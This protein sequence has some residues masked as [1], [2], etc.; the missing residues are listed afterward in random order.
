MGDKEKITKRAAVVSL[1]TMTS[2][3]LGL[4]R[5]MAIATM[6]VSGMRDIFF[7]AFIIPNLFRNLLGEGALS[8]A[9]IPVFNEYLAKKKK[10]EALRVANTTFH[11]LFLILVFLTIIGILI[12]P[13][14]THF[15]G[16]NAEG[17]IL[18][19]GLLRA[20]F[21][22]VIF[23]C[24][25]ALFMGILN[26][27]GNFAV[28]AF[29]PCILN[30]FVIASA[31]T[32]CN[33]FRYPVMGLALGVVLGGAGELLF[34]I[35]FALKKGFSLL[36]RID[37]RHP[38]IKRIG[39]LMLPAAIGLAATPINTVVDQL[40]A[41]LPRFCPTGSV[42]ALWY[43][44]RLFQLPLALFGI[45]IATA[46][47]PTMS[48]QAALKKIEELKETL[49]HALGLAFFTT[50]PASV[51]LI[52][53][54]TPIIRLIFQYKKFTAYDTSATAW[55]LLF[56]SLGL[57]AFGAVIILVRVF[58]SLK[59]T[60]TPARIACFAILSNLVLDLILMRPL[61]QGGLALATSLVAV[62]NMSLL[63]WLLRRR[64]GRLGGRRILA[65]FIR[66]L[67]ASS[68]MGGVSW[69]VARALEPHVVTLGLRVLQVGA[70][71]V[72]GLITLAIVSTILRIKEMR[73]IL[74]I[75]T[76]RAR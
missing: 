52:I 41:S 11:L 12:A 60:K 57:F 58:Y 6:L 63:F 24:L 49:S 22:F 73:T 56:Y 23:I 35:P 48:R 10:E 25:A 34:Q 8:A 61:A 36:P 54:R 21:P 55:A 64:I 9:F 4:V 46:I 32:I 70:A 17:K 50:I 5:D 59:D 45:A 38:A 65:N 20:M 69:L 26:S 3:I 62:L 72:A 47:F 66:I 16:F 68:V 28:P 51:G 42:S 30:I 39:M 31:L 13:A 71:I 15:T 44:N 2:R 74:E 37:Y 76:G 18:T 40:L 14:I 27:L 1:G 67:I 53:L 19:L 33:R 7:F 29:A 43:S 75:V